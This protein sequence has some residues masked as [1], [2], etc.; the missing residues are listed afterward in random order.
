MLVALS[1][2]VTNFRYY[3]SEAQKISA[4]CS[5]GL[6]EGVFQIWSN[7]DE[8]WLF[9]RRFCEFWATWP[10]LLGDAQE[11]PRITSDTFA[12]TLESFGAFDLGMTFKVEVEVKVMGS[13]RGPTLATIIL[14]PRLIVTELWAW[15]RVVGIWFGT[16]DLDMTL[17]SKDMTLTSNAKVEYVRPTRGLPSK[18]KIMGLS[19]T[20]MEI[21]A[22]EVCPCFSI[23]GCVGLP[24]T[25]HRREHVL[26][27]VR[28]SI[29][30]RL[31][32]VGAQGRAPARQVSSRV[33]S[34]VL[35]CPRWPVCRA[36][37]PVGLLLPFA[38]RAAAVEHLCLAWMQPLTMGVGGLNATKRRLSAVHSWHP[39]LS[40]GI[41]GF[42]I[43]DVH[44]GQNQLLPCHLKPCI[45]AGAKR[46][47][48]FQPS[49]FWH[50][51]DF[52]RVLSP[53]S[54]F[55]KNRD[56]PVPNH[57]DRARCDAVIGFP[58][59]LLLFELLGLE[60]DPLILTDFFWAV[61]TPCSK[62]LASRRCGRRHRV[63]RQKVGYPVKNFVQLGP[64]VSELRDFEIWWRRWV[65]VSRPLFD[66]FPESLKSTFWARCARRWLARFL[67]LVKVSVQI[68]FG[69]EKRTNA[70]FR[71]GAKTVPRSQNPI[72]YKVL[73]IASSIGIR[74]RFLSGTF[75]NM[76]N[77]IMWGGGHH[78]T[79]L[80]RSLCLS[81]DAL[82]FCLFHCREM[83]IS[84]GVE[85]ISNYRCVRG[86]IA[87]F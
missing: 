7:C 83:R 70:F 85:I 63:G 61:A 27:H 79:R 64:T 14:G 16:R 36:A 11:W 17:T 43:C 82:D 55:R 12:D 28:I 21:W 54:D 5:R 77:W 71:S 1:P 73:R 69:W 80:G 49:N 81:R 56:D 46:F 23:Q 37:W 6:W 25:R 9:Y 13:T 31:V 57:F 60:N 19:L 44:S 45:Q 62:R 30:P 87:V 51:F 67:L 39:D 24:Y 48:A 18:K 22:F 47:S 3:R 10:K 50:A 72:S 84:L 29:L 2:A 33:S 78:N 42:S 74:S 34:W 75:G 59:A 40:L 66:C 58:L 65:G 52:R 38:M 15:F 53:R 76:R 68:T 32:C 35:G 41:V 8:K 26:E 86:S 4:Q 20:V